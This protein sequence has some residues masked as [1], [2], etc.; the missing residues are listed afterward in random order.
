MK[1][2]VTQHNRVVG[3][4]MDMQDAMD[5]HGNPGKELPEKDAKKLRALAKKLSNLLVAVGLVEEMTGK[6]V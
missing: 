6:F 2:T 5:L 1:L 3:L 4:L